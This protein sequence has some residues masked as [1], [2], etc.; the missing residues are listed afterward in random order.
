VRLAR[1]AIESRIPHSGRMCLLDEVLAWDSVRI[2]CRSRAH[3]T[4]DHPLASSTGLGAATA[5]E[6]AAQAMAVHG[7]L[8]SEE[9][10][11]AMQAGRLAAVR[12]VELLVDRLDYLADDLIIDCERLAGD[13]RSAL[14]EFAVTAGACPVLRG[15]AT[16]ALDPPPAARPG[17]SPLPQ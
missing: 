7:A 12:E 3:R 9:R 8:L 13:E 17:V 15:R 2:S 14:Y 10:T 5:I 16:I 1:A 4:P 6:L 11:I